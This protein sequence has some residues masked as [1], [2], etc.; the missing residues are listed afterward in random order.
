MSR[1]WLFQLFGFFLLC[2]AQL[3]GFPLLIWDGD[4]TKLIVLIMALGIYGIWEQAHQEWDKADA[5]GN[6]CVLVGLI[7]T[8]LGI[9]VA[10]SG[11]NPESVA[12]ASSVKQVVTTMVQGM[13]TVYYTTLVGAVAL[14]WMRL[15]EKF[16]RT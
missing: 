3:V 8:V 6:I 10:L 2:I 15:G 12:D 7:G 1:F 9:I 13:G 5:T 16:C 11:I 4:T 14:A